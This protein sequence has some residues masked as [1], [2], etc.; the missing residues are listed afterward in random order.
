MKFIYVCRELRGALMGRGFFLTVFF[1]GGHFFGSK[2]AGRELSG[3]LMGRG[4][5]VV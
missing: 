1:K 3:Y 4:W 2:L 5:G